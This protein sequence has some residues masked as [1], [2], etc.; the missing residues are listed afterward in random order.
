[1]GMTFGQVFPMN[2]Q[3]VWAYFYN[4]P[5][6][7]WMNQTVANTMATGVGYSVKMNAPQTATFSGQMNMNPVTM[8]LS[9]LNPSTNINRVGWNLLG[10]PFTSALNWNDMILGTG[11][12]GAV[13][14]WNGFTYLSYV[15]GVGSLPGGI[16]PAENGFMV[17]TNVHGSS[18]TIPFAARVHSNIP[19]Y[20]ESVSNLLSLKADANNISDEAFI[21]FNGNAGTGF[22]SQFDAFKLM[23][24]DEAPALY[25]MVSGEILSVN[26]LPMEGNE[27]VDMGFKC[28]VNGTYSLTASGMESFDAT[29]PIWLEDLKTGAVQDLRSNP[30][31]SFSY[32][33]T[34]TENRFRLHFK[35]AYS[36][37]EN[38]LSGINIYSVVRT[39]VIN[40]TTNLSGE[41][42][43]YDMT[44]R[45]LTHATMS[46]Q[47][48]TRIPVNAAVGNYLVKVITENGVASGKVFI[49]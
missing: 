15:G 4:E 22:D 31:Y 39:V 40:N 41:V 49:R 46:S 3:Q 10:N 27:V 43:I 34:D 32:A 36:V 48:E 29:T 26:S 7:M 13:Y 23:G 5:N 42:K 11:V 16:I 30:N 24:I 14:V 9:K 1:M 45:E 20:K 18:V 33:T 6:G 47:N 8:T 37:P 19:F 25:S 21:N 38:S 12:D 44:G 2:Q 28:G 35:S 17:K